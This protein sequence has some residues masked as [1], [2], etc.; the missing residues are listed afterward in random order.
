VEQEQEME[1]FG[2]KS[3]TSDGQVLPHGSEINEDEKSLVCIDGKW[4]DKD[5]LESVGC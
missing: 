2:K 3:C 5:S 1:A 4:V